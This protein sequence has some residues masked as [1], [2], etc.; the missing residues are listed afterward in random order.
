MMVTVLVRDP[1]QIDLVARAVASDAVGHSFVPPTASCS[2]PL[3]VLTDVD[4]DPTLVGERDQCGQCLARVV[5]RHRQWLAAAGW[6][7]CLG[8]PTQ[9]H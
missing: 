3:R 6:A 2:A 9:R 8:R 1:E 7:G 4:E 5:K